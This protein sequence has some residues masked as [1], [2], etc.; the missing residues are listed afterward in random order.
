[1]LM[2]RENAWAGESDKSLMRFVTSRSVPPSAHV[3]RPTPKAAATGFGQVNQAAIKTII[4][5]AV[6]AGRNCANALLMDPFFHASAAPGP[7][8]MKSKAISGAKL[9]L[10]NGGP[11]EMRSPDAISTNKG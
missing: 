9:A 6:A 8:R 4:R 1:R 5:L 7:I 11:T 10:K 2:N 3:A